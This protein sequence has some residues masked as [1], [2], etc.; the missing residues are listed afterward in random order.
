MRRVRL[1]VGG[2]TLDVRAAHALPGL[3]LTRRLTP[4]LETTAPPGVAPWTLELEV[5]EA[6]APVP[7]T[8]PLFDSGGLWKVFRGRRGG[9]LYLFRAP[10]GQGPPARAVAIDAARRR[11]HLFLPPSPWRDTPG[12]A[13]SYPLDELLFQHRL[14]RQGGAVVHASGVALD[15]RAVLFCGASGAGKSTLA[16]LW[17]AAGTR[18]LSDDRLVL[19]RARGGGSLAF[20]TPWHGSGRLASPLGLPL[21]ALFFLRQATRDRARRLA[22]AA[23]LTRLVACTFPPLWE[24]VGLARLLDTAARVVTQVP[25]YELAFR[26]DPSALGCVRAALARHTRQA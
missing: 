5:V 23:A 20:G 16:G 14:A 1:C 11:G 24:A 21:G 19:R 4:F 25:C 9:L 26:R 18:V 17:Q 15:G 2:L 8:P 10:R 12:F 6:P 22:P 13:L 7:C 3:R